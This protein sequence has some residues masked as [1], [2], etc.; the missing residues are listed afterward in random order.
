[1]N[2]KENSQLNIGSESQ[3]SNLGDL[4]PTSLEAN[5]AQP[6]IE[7]RI[8]RFLRNLQKKY[9]Q[10]IKG[11]DKKIEEQREDI[12]KFEDFVRGLEGQALEDFLASYEAKYAEEQK[13]SQDTNPVRQE[14]PEED[15]EMD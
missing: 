9:S 15:A 1:M 7:A 2:G 10:Y 5:D 14:E 6:S 8:Q 4:E 13:E 3:G 11:N 12:Q